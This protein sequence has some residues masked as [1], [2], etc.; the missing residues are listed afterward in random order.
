MGVQLQNKDSE[1]SDEM[2]GAIDFP[3]MINKA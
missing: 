1:D 2:P 3:P